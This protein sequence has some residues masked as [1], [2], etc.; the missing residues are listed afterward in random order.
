MLAWPAIGATAEVEVPLARPAIA[1]FEAA[2]LISIGELGKRVR[3][4]NLGVARAQLQVATLAHQ[5]DAAWA[6]FLPTLTLSAA[7]VR[8]DGFAQGNFGDLQEVSYGSARPYGRLELQLNPLL[9]SYAL[10]SAS[11]QIEA[12]HAGLE[13]IS[14]AELLGAAEAYLDLV[15]AQA[16]FGVRGDAL[17]SAEDLHAIATAT[18]Q[19]GTGSATDA[20][21]ART[22]VARQRDALASAELEIRLSSQALAERLHLPPAEAL[23]AAQPSLRVEPWAPDGLEAAGLL[24]QAE[25]HRPELREK[26][27]AID[28]A[29][30]QRRQAI[31]SLAAPT[32]GAFAQ[33]AGVGTGYENLAGG[34]LSYGIGVQWDLSPW[35]Y[36]ET[37]T[38]RDREKDAHVVLERSRDRVAREV[39]DAAAGVRTARGRLEPAREAVESA[40]EARKLGEV[41]YRAGS[42]SATE[43]IEAQ[44]D[45]DAARLGLV[46]VL[47]SLDKAQLRLLFAL[48][49]LDARTLAGR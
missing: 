20:L 22:Q 45:L 33:L 29:G 1:G 28:A 12:A 6:R 27:H 4:Q 8:V 44:R 2:R 25:A 34:Q 18:V 19:G 17:R 37:R 35:R 11:R 39:L 43:V 40:T 42:G 16:A 36:F 26:R 5:R 31:A 48:G 38:A 9:A 14:G 41:R 10:A 32:I 21:R 46:E 47:V 24:R 30:A 3:E 7:Y 23:L 49:A 15:R 13:E